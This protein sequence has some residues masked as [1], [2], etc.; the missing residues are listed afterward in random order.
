MQCFLGEISVR[1]TQMTFKTH[2]PLVIFFKIIGKLLRVVIKIDELHIGIAQVNYCHLCPPVVVHCLLWGINIE[3]FDIFSGTAC[4]F[5][6][7][8][9][10]MG[11]RT[12][13]RGPRH[14]RKLE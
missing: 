12:E 7:H 3:H 13:I 4:Q 2:I 1:N 5:V 10:G 9:M 6:E 11:T 8:F 14:F